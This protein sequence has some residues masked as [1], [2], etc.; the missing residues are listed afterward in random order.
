MG[1]IT[2]RRARVDVTGARQR[3]AIEITAEIEITVEIAAAHAPEVL[4]PVRLAAALARARSR[5]ARREGEALEI[6]V[7][8][9]R[10]GRRQA[11][12]AARA[13]VLGLGV[14]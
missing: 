7:E 4:E 12:E 10:V 3:L 11:R 14:G 9:G 2:G 13:R 5:V 8:V 6:E 1:A